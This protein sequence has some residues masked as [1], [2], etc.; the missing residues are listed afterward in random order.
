MAACRDEEGR[1]VEYLLAH[2]AKPSLMDNKVMEYKAKP[3]LMDN[4]VQEHKAK[5]SLI[6]NKVKKH[7]AKLPLMGYKV[8]E[9]KA[10]QSLTDIKVMEVQ[11]CGSGIIYSGSGSEFFIF[12]L[13]IR[14]RLGFLNS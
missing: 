5:P 2:K 14:I 6:D 11:G 12:E 13:R 7:K 9:H 3:F 10:K 1:C 4:K 8:K